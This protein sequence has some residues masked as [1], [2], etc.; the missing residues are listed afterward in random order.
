M[1]LSYMIDMDESSVWMM[2]TAGESAKASLPYVQ[3][4]GDFISQGKYYTTREGLPS[5][6]IKYTL[7]GEGILEY[8]GN[9]FRIPGGHFF[10]IDCEKPQ[11]YHTSEHTGEWRVLWVDFY[12]ATSRY[13]YEQFLNANN[14]SNVGALPDDSSVPTSIYA[15][16]DLY[17]EK[18]GH[19]SDIHASSILTSIMVECITAA[20]RKNSGTASRYV[21]E[22]R[23]YILSHFTEKISLEVL[24]KHLLLNKYYLQKLFRQHTGQTPNEYLSAL[25]M[26]H[27][28][29]LLR[30]TEK[31]V[32]LVAAE[33]GIEN[34]SHFIKQF[35][36][37]EGITPSNYR[38]RWQFQ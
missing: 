1:K 28:K 13:Y 30:T 19:I 37:S 27:A 11:H 24:A 2:V 26:N 4:L 29:E 17:K 20:T 7:S 3:E 16:M 38:R 8:E 14:G 35:K 23:D 5:Y 15:L 36:T 6:L 18:A 12:G 34:V 9:A 21:R 33:I 31:P 10:W 25:R 32:N 22:A